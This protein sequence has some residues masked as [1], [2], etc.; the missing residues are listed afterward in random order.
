MGM[1]ISV[2]AQLVGTP[3]MTDPFPF[4]GLQQNQFGIAPTCPYFWMQ[5]G[6]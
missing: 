4:F 1:E 6:L 2:E 5:S 3:N